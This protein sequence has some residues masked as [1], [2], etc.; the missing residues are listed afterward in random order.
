MTQ[1][2][3]RI[4][5]LCLM[6][7]PVMADDSIALRDAFRF[8]EA[9]DWDGAQAVVASAGQIARD[10]VE[11]RRL[12]AGKGDLGQYEAFLVRR[13]DWPGMPLLREKGEVAV[14]RSSTAARVIAYFGA[15]KPETAAGSL[16]LI[17]ALGVGDAAQ[18]EAVRAWLTLSFT[19]E[20]EDTLLGLYGD[21]LKTQH[22]QRLDRLLWEDR[23][24]EA[25]RMLVRVSDDWRALATARLALA[26][27]A[28]NAP[29]L[30]EAVPKAVADDAGLAY[31][32]FVWRMRKDRTDDA[33]A[34]ILD[35][36]SNAERLGD[37]AMW[38]DRRASLAR[39]LMR[40]G[41][42]REAYQ[43]AA[44][45]WLN[46][47]ADYADLEFVA[48]FVALRKLGD[49]GAALTHFQRLQAAVVTPISLSRA[50]Y[51]QGRAFEALGRDAEAEAAY[52]AAAKH[53][54]AYY[55][56]LAAERLGLP[57]DA[58][59]L[60]DTRPAD[61][62]GAAFADDSV[63][64]A[65]RMILAAGDRTLA[66]RFVLHLAE[67]LDG[68]ELD[69]LADMALAM[70]EPHIALLVAK[71]AAERG[72][73]LPRAYFPV[74]DLVP[75]GLAVSRALA[76]SIARR[77]SEFDVAV[78]SP[79]GARGLMQVMPGTAKL[80]SSVTGM[81]Y[82]AGKLTTDAGYN[83]AHGAAYLRTLVDEF[84][85][86]VA[87]VASGYN[88]GPGRPRRWV[89]EFGDPRDAAVDV[90]DWVETIPFAETRTY[91]MRV[92]ESLVIYRAKLK[93]E[94]GPVR[95]SAELR[96]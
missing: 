67:G 30:V 68:V 74:T 71:A 29:A 5:A 37:P 42:A 24:G 18:A 89:L 1:M 11:W 70:D 16:A 3:A 20:E 50:L 57:L 10:V 23:P 6:I 27:E 4:F 64:V 39:L 65:A 85:P 44:G 33:V 51:W 32:R 19:A 8:A 72:V 56:L 52:K 58:S 43:V 87:L 84:G 69:Q 80:M 7:L 83:V 79:A 47:G 78:V 75:D 40:T 55:G 14:A 66:K 61:W 90:V 82:D 26:A 13:A 22:W 91:V 28:A 73:I 93:G 9:G 36:S 95:I 94:A 76:L 96:G 53:A 17:R 60:S 63:L 59:V 21:V 92:V 62:Q 86:S 25:S 35:R 12:R 41:R 45:H 46:D 88:A 81:A 48:G 77:E 38:A 15:G 31:A 2:I 49:A 34:M 54:T